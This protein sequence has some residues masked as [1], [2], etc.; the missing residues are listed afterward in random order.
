MNDNKRI[1]VFM[2]ILLLLGALV[3]GLLLTDTPVRA[4]AQNM[5]GAEED[6]LEGPDEP[7]TGE[8]L[9]R[10]SEAALDYL[11]END[12]GEGRVTDSEVGDEEGYYEIEVTLESGRQIDVHLD[13]TFNVLGREADGTGDDE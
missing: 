13:E 2:G 9:E 10:A 11:R 5:T 4:F 7:V 1:F 12:L 3:G 8:A 6:S